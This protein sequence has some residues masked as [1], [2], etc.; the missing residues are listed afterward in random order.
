MTITGSI[1]A[2]L[3]LASLLAASAGT[4]RMQIE[5]VAIH[6]NQRVIQLKGEIRHVGSGTEESVESELTYEPS[7]NAAQIGVAAKDG[8]IRLSGYVPSYWEKIAAERATERV[9]GVEAVVNELEVKLPGSSE[10]TDEDIARAAVNALEWSVLVPPNRVK[11]KVSKGWVTLEG[12]VDWQFQKS[13]AEKAVRKLLGVKGVSNLI[14]VQP[15]VNSKEVKSEIENALKR[16]AELDADQIR[17]EAQG[18]RVI[19]KG[20][21]HSWFE[22]EEAEKAAWRAPGVREVE[23]DLVVAA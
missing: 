4:P 17:V 8:I 14:S 19:L 3:Q 5:H 13:A 16:S 9:G 7:I 18:D 22:R 20:T 15:R 11:I 23:D 21:V 2:R 6:G 10:R 1:R 12:N